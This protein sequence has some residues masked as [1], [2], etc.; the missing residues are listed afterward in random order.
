MSDQEIIQFP[1][2]PGLTS[3]SSQEDSK[4]IDFVVTP[5]RDTSD[6]DEGK[7]EKHECDEKSEE[8]IEV[9]SEGE[10]TSNSAPLSIRKIE[11][12]V[13]EATRQEIIVASSLNQDQPPIL[14]GVVPIANQQGQI[15][16]RIPFMFPVGMPL[17]QAFMVYDKYADETFEKFKEE[18]QNR[19]VPA[20]QIPRPPQG[21]KGSGPEIIVP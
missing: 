10:N 19:I 9:T 16:G 15:V 8:T 5:G 3:V 14:Q 6:E 4:P 7:K 11:T 2:P 18:Q 13:N 1:N 12:Y 17:L 21:R 20:T